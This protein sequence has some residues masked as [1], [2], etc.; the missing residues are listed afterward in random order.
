M[1]LIFLIIAPLLRW[2]LLGLLLLIWIVIILKL[3]RTDSLSPVRRKV[4]TGLNTLLFLM[5]GLFLF[6][7]VMPGRKAGEILLVHDAAVPDGVTDSVM[8]AR[9]IKYG[10]SY[11]E[12]RKKHREY[13]GHRFLFLGQEAEPGLLSHLAGKEVQWVPYFAPETLQEIRWHGILRRGERQT[14]SGK[15][16]LS[17]PG[18]L[19]LAYGS[20]M[21]DS[22]LLEK[23]FNA[24]QLSFPVFTEGRNIF[25]LRLDNRPL[26][27]IAFYARPARPLTIT[28][29]QDYPDFESRTLAEWLGAQGHQVEIYTPVAQEI[30]YESRVNKT[31]DK[32][33]ADLVIATPSRAGD[34]RVKK[35]V[36]ENRSVLFY[37]LQD[38]TDALTRINRATGAAFS[39]RRI[40]L[41]ESLPFKNELTMLPFQLNGRPNQ[42]QAGSLPVSFQ[43]NGA[44]VA[45]SLMNE[46]FPARLSGDTLAYGE[47]WGDILAAL[48]MSDSVKI[49]VE[50][51]VFKDIPAKIIL[52]TRESTLSPDKDT[53]YLDS[54]PVNPARKSGQ[55]TFSE[56]GWKSLH[57]SGEVYVED[58]PAASAARLKNW[59]KENAALLKSET[60]SP[61]RPVSAG[62]WFWAIFLC[63]AA[64]WAEAKFRY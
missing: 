21:L 57:A 64:L 34:A 6:Q 55:Y 42:R 62:I 54:S 4:K 63:L 36:A 61:A 49:S 9:K 3:R 28:L 46:T 58:T 43:K 50:A 48:D 33:G 44:R 20:E 5:L 11:K 7:P 15:I 2:T 35:A 1:V 39:A 22:L 41:Q 13:T 17:R 31:P 47:I 56:T 26:Q 27:D 37:G 23:G 52:Q 14:V 16:S 45:V 30:L 40:S 25:S 60:S 10:I 51:P 18:T 59:L 32:R 8:T 19:K 38:V 29:L 12:F 53:L 24:F